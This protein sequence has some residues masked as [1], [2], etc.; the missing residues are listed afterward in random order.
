[1]TYHKIYAPHRRDPDTKKIDLRTW[2]C[3]EFYLLQDFEWLWTEKIDGT[4]I[5]VIWDGYRISFSG[6]TDR[7]IIPDV[8]LD[9]LNAT[10]GS[11]E[12]ET[13]F[14]QSFGDTPTVLYGEGYGPKI[15]AG[16]QYGDHGFVLFDVVVGSGPYLLPVD[17]KGVAD[18][19]GVG[20]VPI[21]Y[22]CSLNEMIG[23][24]R[25]DEVKSRFGTDL[26]EG[27]VG[28]PIGGLLN[29]NGQRII[30]KIKNRDY[31]GLESR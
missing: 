29:R 1:M 20:C 11:P 30:T 4:N 17:V 22:Q 6:R 28:Y 23:K 24:V 16:K 26:A 19:L 8:L 21:L 3:A 12:S 5:R 2:Y 15:N 25:G 13:L 9:N 27:V 7:A 31:Y 14:E 18:N 10:L